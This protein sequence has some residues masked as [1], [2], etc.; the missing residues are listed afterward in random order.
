MLI[1]K[2]VLTIAFVLAMKGIFG[3]EEKKETNDSK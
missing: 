3:P 2:I 1:L